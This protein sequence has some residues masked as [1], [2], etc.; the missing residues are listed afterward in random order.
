MT[1]PLSLYDWTDKEQ[2]CLTENQE[3][4]QSAVE[5]LAEIE[6]GDPRFMIVLASARIDAALIDLFSAYR[7]G[8]KMPG[9]FHRRSSVALEC[10]LIDRGYNRFAQ[11]VRTIRNRIVHGTTRASSLSEQPLASFVRKIHDETSIIP[12]WPDGPIAPEDDL[13]RSVYASMLAGVVAI[14]L[15]FFDEAGKLVSKGF[16][17]LLRH[18]F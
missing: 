3:R 7:E 9:V 18:C 14:E 5:M 10:G 2:G 8:R 11:H 4:I 6:S 17:S 16:P 12:V 15:D 1:E 13:T